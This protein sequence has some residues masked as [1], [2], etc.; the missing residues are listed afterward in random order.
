MIA[1]K[2]TVVEDERIVALHMKQQLSKLGYEV[3][4][5]VAAG[6]EAL[7]RIAELRPDLVLMDIH[8]EGDLDGIETAA[9]IPP[10]LQIP[11]IYVT[12]YSEQ[13]TLERARTTKPYGFLVKPF[14]ERELNATIQMALERH[15]VDTALRTSQEQVRRERDAAQRYLDVAGVMILALDSKGV[16]TLINRRG[17]AILGYD[18]PNDIVGKPWIDNF[19][20]KRIRGEMRDAF[21]RLL[22]G[23]DASIEFYTNPVLTKTGEERLISWHNSTIAEENGRSTCSLSSGEDIT[24]RKRAEDNVRLSEERFRS[25]FGAV[26]EGIFIVD[27]ATGTFVETN[28]AGY[29]MFGYAADELIGSDIQALSSGVP[30]YTQREAG[31]WIQKAAATGLPQRFD[32]HCKTKAGRLFWAEISIQFASISNRE[33]A[34]AIMRDVTERRVIEEQLRQ[35]QKM[36]VVEQLTGG[37]AHDFNNLL[38]VIM[39][40]LDLV[41]ERCGKD[42]ELDEMAS[43]ALEAATRGADLIRRLLAFSR[44]QPLRPERIE[45]NQLVAGM[46]KLLRRVLG[47]NIEISL[48]TAAGAWTVMADPTQLEA[49]IVNLA[50]NARDAM[51]EGGKLSIAIRNSHL[52]EDYT[53]SYAEVTAGDYVAIE[54][55]D[56]G[57]GIPPEILGRIFEPFFTTK[58]P[59]K[60]TGLGLSMVFGFMK[61]SGGHVSVYS[62]P[63]VGTTFRLYLPRAERA[64][65]AAEATERR[66][67]P[68]GGSEKVLVV[69]D[70][71]GMRRTVSRRLR[72]LGYEVR[73]AEN[74]ARALDILL[75]EEIDL[76]FT[77]VVMPGAIDGAK[78]ARTAMER[79]PQLK[80][81]LTSGFSEAKLDDPAFQGFRLLSK[82][83]RKEEL[84]RSLREALG[85]GQT[86]A[87]DE[88][89]GG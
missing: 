45:I 68:K 62:E 37:M 54:V 67:K 39:V 52:D 60:G 1:A 50:T 26:S 25:I 87:G 74:A 89:P 73:E 57:A 66:P 71:D 77:D 47:E 32:W 65:E 18:D 16:V 78:L 58:G 9:R 3:V 69:E 51:P 12:A 35:A 7:Q 56:T 22:A 83:Y 53:R 28:T 31:E 6:E 75:R 19:I 29:V 70:N 4:A 49:A 36:E 23:K 24:E 79:W 30:P 34:L 84:A 38:A 64:V 20:P 13:A 2:I 76:L 17:C 88:P 21:G 40:N 14:S 10:E 42:D 63:G 33:V 15:R 27:A 86:S 44:R 46:V 43:D 61:Q 5:V 85:E 11:V 59:A 48:K 82:P 8:I 80:V 72:D 55:S 81:L 41:R